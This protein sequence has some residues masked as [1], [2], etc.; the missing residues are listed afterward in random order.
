[1]SDDMLPAQCYYDLGNF[2]VEICY[3]TAYNCDDTLF[4]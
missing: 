3:T 1:M 2:L 4:Q